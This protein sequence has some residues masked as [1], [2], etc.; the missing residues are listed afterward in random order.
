MT[1]HEPIPIERTQKIEIALNTYEPRSPNLVQIHDLDH[2][3]A[4]IESELGEEPDVSVS[5]KELRGCIARL[6]YARDK[7]SPEAEQEALESARRAN[8]SLQGVIAKK[9]T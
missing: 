6:K 5:L 8:S 4:K 9:R 3:I 2:Q 1:D 7:K